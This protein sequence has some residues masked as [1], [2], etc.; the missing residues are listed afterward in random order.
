MPAPKRLGVGWVDGAAVDVLAADWNGSL[1]GGV[2]PKMLPVG[3]LPKFPKRFEPVFCIVPEADCVKDEGT[4]CFC[5]ETDVSMASFDGALSPLE[6]GP[7]KLKL[8]PLFEGGGAK[9]PKGL[10]PPVPGAG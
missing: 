2:W 6:G 5:G 1:L 3:C 9:L 8:N 10:L 4:G 7:P